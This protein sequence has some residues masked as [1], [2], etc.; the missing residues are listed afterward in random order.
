MLAVLAGQA[1]AD[2]ESVQQINS[3]TDR[4]LRT[5]YMCRVAT[6]PGVKPD[7]AG[8]DNI[9]VD[10]I[11]MAYADL[12]GDGSLEFISGA[13]DE[14]FASNDWMYRNGNRDR[15][16]SSHQ[17]MFFSPDPAFVRPDGTRFLMA[18]TIVVQDFNGDGIDD[19]AFIQHGPDYAPFEPRR[20]E[21]MLSGTDGYSVGYLPGPR[22]LWNGGA[23]GDIDGDG[24]IDLL[25]T[26][27][28]NDEIAAYINDGA[29]GFTYRLLVGEGRHKSQNARHFNGFL[30][31]FDGDGVLD[32]LADGHEAQASIYWGLA[33]VH[34]Q[35]GRQ[36]SGARLTRCSR[37]TLNGLT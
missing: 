14:P 27:G 19:A 21:V 22:S 18:R 10:S 17:Y 9:R 4:S 24:D 3:T 28:P 8:M 7:F 23:A 15:S 6:E 25:A 35:S 20:S 34:L 30:W 1:T 31:D 5:Q 26:P 11:N 36:C 12:Y 29:G 16:R 32:I 2:E 33:T 13:S 37:R